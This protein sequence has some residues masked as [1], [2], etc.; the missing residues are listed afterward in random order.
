[1]REIGVFFDEATK[2]IY[3]LHIYP[4]IMDKRSCLNRKEMIK[5]NLGISERTH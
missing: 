1:M 3:C 2:R 5:E 4:R